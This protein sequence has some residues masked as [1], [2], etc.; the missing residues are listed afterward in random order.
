MQVLVDA[1]ACPVAV[2]DILFRA[3]RRV[4]I[5]VTLVANQY[6]R[7]PP[8]RFIKALQVPAGFDAADNRIV[9]LVASGDLVITADIPLAAAALDKGA[10]VLDPRG[11]WFTR[12]NIQERLT[13][14][15]VLDQLRTSGVDTGGPAP[16]TPQDSKA[17]AGQLDRFLARHGSR[18]GGV[19]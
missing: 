1:D 4:E 16:Y 3:A 5:S 2:K 13:M 10:H 15:D 14:R 17:F 7:T 12:E 18:P 6:L 19:A 9:E 11:N 8:S